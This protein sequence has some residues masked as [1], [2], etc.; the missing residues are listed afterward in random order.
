MDS[1]HERQK[2]VLEL[3]AEGELSTQGDIVKAL[4]KRG[5]RA[6]QVSVSRDIV[7]LGLVKA[8]GTYRTAAAGSGAA[9]PELP[10]RTWLRSAESAGPNL[11]VLRC[12]PGTAQ[13]VARALDVVSPSGV[14]GTVAGDDTI[15][16][17]MRTP[18]DGAAFVDYLRARIAQRPLP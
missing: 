16:V 7:E 15:F 6:T 5:I 11:V 10:L 14:V 8:G 18:K 4:A 2:A 9:D 17:A 3:V 1:K 12:D 13:G